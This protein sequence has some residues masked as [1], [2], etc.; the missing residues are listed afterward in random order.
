[1]EAMDIYK[2]GKRFGEVLNDMLYLELGQCVPKRRIIALYQ[3][4]N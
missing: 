1:M 2:T 4:I 3:T